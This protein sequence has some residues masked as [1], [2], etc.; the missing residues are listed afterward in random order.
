MGSAEMPSAK[1]A[2]NLIRNRRTVNPK[3]YLSGGKISDGDLNTI[4]QGGDCI[5]RSN[6]TTQG[7]RQTST[8]LE[9]NTRISPH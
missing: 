2:F 3:D 1:Q 5:T 8:L 9:I 7:H 4:L 6:P